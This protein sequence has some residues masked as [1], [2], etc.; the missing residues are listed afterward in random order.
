M[1]HE[2]WLQ[3]FEDRYGPGA[4]QR[5]MALLDQPCVS[6]ADIAL[7]FGVTRERVR[8]WHLKLRPDAPRG[9]ARKRLCASHRKKRELFEDTLFRSFY[10]HARPHLTP[11]QLTL[12]RTRDGYAHRLVR[13][14]AWTVAL[15]RAR[16]HSESA[17]GGKPAYVLV[18]SQRRV[19]YIYYWLSEDDYLLLPKTALPG[20]RTTFLDTRLSKYQRFRNT[21]EAMLVDGKVTASDDFAPARRLLT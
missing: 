7:Q 5:L 2:R 19:D 9:H 15:K 16:R 11:G 8:Q 20:E 14:E 13:L 4:H 17:A 3:I 12:V 1:A 21:F 10:R 18:N 6:F